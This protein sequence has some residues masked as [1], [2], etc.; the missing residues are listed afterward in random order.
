MTARRKMHE[1]RPM[2]EAEA[3]EFME[4]MGHKQLLFKN[5]KTDKISMVYKREV[6]G[7]GLVEPQDEV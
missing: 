1:M 6:G 2:D 4:L 7:Y 5:K 3:I